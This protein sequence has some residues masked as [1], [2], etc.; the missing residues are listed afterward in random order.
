MSSGTGESSGK[1]LGQAV[2]I[3]EGASLGSPA[4]SSE[5]DTTEDREG[6]E[7]AARDAQVEKIYK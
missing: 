4:A 1:S 6:G 3:Y 2:D 5:R 7:E